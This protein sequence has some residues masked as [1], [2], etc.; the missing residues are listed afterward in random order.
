M[1]K[2]IYNRSKVVEPEVVSP[3]IS[4]PIV[5]KQ[6]DVPRGTVK[7]KV[8]KEFSDNNHEVEGRWYTNSDNHPLCLECLHREDMHHEWDITHHQAMRKNPM[9]GVE[10]ETRWTDKTK[11]YTRSRPCQHACKCWVYK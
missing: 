10:I 8:S 9:T 7:P 2:G 11:N 3:V 5:E 4:Q 1:P 6:V